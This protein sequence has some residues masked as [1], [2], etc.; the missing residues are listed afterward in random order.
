MILWTH[1]KPIV[2]EGAISLQ[3]E[4]AIDMMFTSIV[5]RGEVMSTPDTGFTVKVDAM[6]LS[7]GKTYFYRFR[8][9]EDR[10]PVGT[11]RTLPDAS[12]S[13]V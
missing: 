4:V 3:Y 6:G 1:A 7:P 5:S 10:S 2:G 9:G 12:A 13:E 8:R 11:T